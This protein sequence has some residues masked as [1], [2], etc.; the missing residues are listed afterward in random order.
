MRILHIIHG[1][2][3]Y[4]MAGSEVYAYN[5][6]RELSK[7][8]N[9]VFVFSRIENPFLPQY[10]L[11]YDTVDNVSVI[12]VNKP[13][14]YSL[15]QKYMDENI[16]RIVSKILEDIKPDIVHIQHLSHLSTNIVNIIKEKFNIPIVF[17]V[18][19]FWMFCIRGQLITPEYEICSGPDLKKC[20]K[21]LSYLQASESDIEEYFAHMRRVI[22]NIDYFLIPSKFICDFFIKMGVE[23][24]KIIYS[25]YGFKKERINFRKKEYSAGSKITFGFLGRIIPAKGVHILIESFNMIKNKRGAVLKIYGNHQGV[26]EYLDEISGEN[27]FFMGGYHNND[28]NNVLESIDVLIVPSIWYENSP[29]VIQEAFLKGIPVITSNIGGMAEFVKDGEDGFLFEVGNIDSLHQV[30]EKIIDNPSILNELNVNRD[31]VRDIND[32]VKSLEELYR[33]LIK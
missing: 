15:K 22:E 23:K 18:H 19:D 17:T 10:A 20:S 33:R 26:K 6:T 7:N 1:F 11:K 3:P 12:R 13:R 24:N 5:I 8:N 28:L 27:I 16:D 21:C 2:P 14:E 31:K 30:M 25:P 29:L 32:D 9:E 4:Y